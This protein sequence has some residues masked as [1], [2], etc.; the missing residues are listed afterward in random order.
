VAAWQVFFFLVWMNVIR[1]KNANYL[2]F[3]KI[4]TTLEKMF[5]FAM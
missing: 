3:K 1:P 4:L 2:G 5:F